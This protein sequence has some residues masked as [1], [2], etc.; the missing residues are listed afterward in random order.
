MSFLAVGGTL[1]AGGAV[2]AGTIGAGAALAGTAGSIYSA[3]QTAKAANNA[4]GQQRTI[5]NEYLNNLKYQP[6]DIEKLKR[7]ATAQAIQNATQSL[8]LERSLQP[9][10]ANTRETLAQQVNSELAQGGNLPA[11]VANK[12]AMESRTIGARSGSLDNAAPITAARLGI[13]SLDLMRNRQN[14]AANLLAA[15]PLQPTGLDPGSVAAAEVAQ[16]AAMNQFNI[17][18]A[19]TT[20]DAELGLTDAQAKARGAEIGGQTGILSAAIGGLSSLAGLGG[21]GGGTSSLSAP[22]YLQKTGTPY[23]APFSY[24]SYL[25]ASPVS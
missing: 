16:N 6:I 4:V 2:T 10:V 14:A 11:D 9:N 5:T 17:D 19:K 25:A 3:R 1:I 12:V 23:M 18:K 22:S 21:I 20:Y 15:N 13:T 24:K 8:A 7:D